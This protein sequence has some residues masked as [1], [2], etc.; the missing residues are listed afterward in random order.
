[1]TEINR[2][3]KRKLSNIDFSK[4]GSHIALVSTAQG[5]PASGHDYALVMKAVNFSEEFIQKA[6]EIKVTLEITEFLRR[7]FNIYSEE[8]EVLA[9]ALGFTTAMQDRAAAEAV[10]DAIE[11]EDEPSTYEDYIQSKMEAFEVMKALYEA[12]SIP[13]VLS[14]LDED[15]YLAMLKDQE[16]LEKAFK[17][18]TK[19]QKNS[20]KTI[21]VVKAGEGSTEAIAKAE[22]SDDKTEAKVEP[23]ETINKGTSMTKE[24]QVAEIEKTVEVVEKSQLDAIQ[25]AFNE[26]K[27][28]LQKALDLVAKFETERKE[29][30]RKARLEQVKTAV[31]DQAKAEVLFKALGLVEDETDFQAVVKTL[32]DMQAVIEKSDLFVEQGVQVEADE[33]VKESAVAR[34]IKARLSK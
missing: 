11:S 26:Q 17:K 23:S 20:A 3:A 2:K 14:K 28:E 18:I 15:E 34:V 8:A 6:S 24:V 29:A 27:E 4:Q 10:D 19:D 7:F 33:K 5:G 16:R 25:K 1:M 30:I 31:K 9:R 13:E 21:P 22:Q 12:D 32:A